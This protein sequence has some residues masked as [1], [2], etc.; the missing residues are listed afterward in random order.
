LGKVVGI[1]PRACK[2]KA[3]SCWNDRKL[4]GAEDRTTFAPSPSTPKIITDLTFG[5][6]WANVAV[7]SIAKIQSAFPRHFD[8]LGLILDDV[9][10]IRR[11][12]ENGP[13]ECDVQGG[14]ISSGRFHPEERARV[15]SGARTPLRSL[16]A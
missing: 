8:M 14:C 5:E 3:D 1:T 4:G 10:T 12:I 6:G 16:T 15:G 7:A 9:Q 2:L 13:P 11:Q